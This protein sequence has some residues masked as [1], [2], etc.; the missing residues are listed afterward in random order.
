MLQPPKINAPSWHIK[1]RGLLKMLAGAPALGMLR[2][3][4]QSAAGPFRHGVASGDP[5][6]DRVILWTRLMPEAGLADI[7]WEVAKDGDFSAI[8]ASGAAKTSAA[9]DFTVKV[10]ASGLAPG[11]RYYYRFRAGGH[12]SPLGRT[13]TLPVGAVDRLRLG[14]VSCANYPYGFFHA[15]R[16]IAQR[17]DID[18]VIH[19]GD[20]IYEYPRGHYS[21]PDIEA[22]GRVV[23]P[24]GESIHL[25]DYRARYATYRADPDLAAA[26]A[27]HPFIAIWDDHEIANDAWRDGAEN[28]NDGEGD[29]PARRAA[30]VQ[31]YM[32]WMPIRENSAGPREAI[33]RAFDF[34]DLARLIMLDTRLIGRDRQLSYAVDLEPEAMAANAPQGA[35]PVPDIARFRAE[36]L[37]EEA[38]TMLGARQEAW[39]RETL[40]ASKARGQTWQVLG[41]QV[42]MGNLNIP[43][44]GEAL[45]EAEPQFAAERIKGLL[46]LG[47]FG[48]PL[49]L[50]AWGGYPAARRRLLADVLE[51]ANNALVLAGDSHNGW[52]FNLKQ[53]GVI[54]AAEFATPSVTS[55]G[56]ETYLPADPARI[57][58]ALRQASDELVWADTARRGYLTL[59]LTRQAASADFWFLDSVAG[60][61]FTIAREKS[62]TT[63]AQ[64]MAGVGP[65]L[66]A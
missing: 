58:E 13:R 34:G 49:N 21:A 62:L 2:A 53:N 65:L 23:A 45:L 25:T 43:K 7:V 40:A 26:H 6:A 9:R 47:P 63:M 50:D 5:L 4:A 8:V 44:D 27:A 48:L 38:R 14:V 41:Q 56:L 20:Y 17:E 55:P 66:E 15:Y 12:V 16:H 30:A 18:A 36:K 11:S 28:H 51:H 24:P 22:G 35:Q 60:Q 29:W 31:A 32:E 61:E 3:T 33:Y 10:D 37:G 46:A 59:S 64:D 52:A 19:L 39:L 1:R 54:A 42:V 57:A